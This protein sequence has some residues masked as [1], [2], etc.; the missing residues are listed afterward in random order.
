LGGLASD[1]F[2]D[3]DI[4]RK[5]GGEAV[6]VLKVD[7]IV[8]GKPGFALWVFADEDLEREI[9]GGGGSGEH[10]GSAAFWVAENKEFCVGHFEAGFF[11]FAAV[12]DDGK[13][14]DAV[15]LQDEFEFRDGFVDGMIAGDV[16]DAVGIVAR[17]RERLAELGWA[18]SLA[19][20]RDFGVYWR[21]EAGR[22]HE[23]R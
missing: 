4:F 17:H 1:R 15:G 11:G 8:V 19:R 20:K 16:G 12:V 7:G 14:R 13:E 9:N 3:G 21:T 18:E 6:T 10:E 23:A 22:R 2:H 5:V